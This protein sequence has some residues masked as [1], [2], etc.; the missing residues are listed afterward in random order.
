MVWPQFV[1]VPQI[2]AVP[3]QVYRCTPVL[4]TCT[5]CLTSRLVVEWCHG[6]RKAPTGPIGPRVGKNQVL[7]FFRLDFLQ[8]EGI[9]QVSGGLNPQKVRTSWTSVQ[10]EAD[11]AIR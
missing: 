3:Q 9:L 1:V 10:Y 7:W 4:Y 8:R 6:E 11:R 5:P 2:E